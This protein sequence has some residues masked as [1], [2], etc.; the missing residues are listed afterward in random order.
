MGPLGWRLAIEFGPPLLFLAASRLGGILFGTAV[1][2][3]ATIVAGIVSWARERRVPILPLVG[4][5]F[6]LVFGGM[7]LALEDPVW[8]MRQPTVENLAASLLLGLM[9]AKGWFPLRNIF[10]PALDLSDAVWRAITWRLVLF[11]AAL[12]G[13]NEF[14]WRTYGVDEWLAFKAFFLPAANLAFVLCQW[15]MVRRELNRQ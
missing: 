6:V 13:L 2:I 3:A 14:V 12:A 5:A 4:S 7:T 9:A 11:L 8:V 15:L 10:G 1:F